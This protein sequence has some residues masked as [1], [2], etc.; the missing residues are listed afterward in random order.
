MGAKG[1]VQ[2][3]ALLPCALALALLPQLPALCAET[4]QTPAAAAPNVTVSFTGADLLEALHRVFV[5]TNLR[6]EAPRDVTQRFSI[7]VADVPLE[8]ALHMLLEPRGLAFQREGDLYRVVHKA[9]FRSAGERLDAGREERLAREWLALTRRPRKP[10]ER[11][12]V[13][14]LHAPSIGVSTTSIG[15]FGPYTPAAPIAYYSPAPIAG[16]VQ[17]TG[18][19]DARHGTG[20]GPLTLSLPEGVSLGL[21][22]QWI[23]GN[24]LALPAQGETIIRGPMGETRIPFSGGGS[25][26]VRRK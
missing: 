23:S 9:S 17:V 22:Q 21:L 16:N 14:F 15:G 4:P 24:G 19:R 1:V 13:R 20:L 10:P 6:Y 26:G 8:K 7:N 3:K 2:M 11:P 5:G 25:L 18:S 12:S